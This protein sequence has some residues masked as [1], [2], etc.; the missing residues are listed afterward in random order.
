MQMLT[1]LY[2]CDPCMQLNYMMGIHCSLKQLN[3]YCYV[4][5]EYCIVLY[6]GLSGPFAVLYC[7]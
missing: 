2:A 1:L 7:G 5:Y 3:G 6:S 4:L